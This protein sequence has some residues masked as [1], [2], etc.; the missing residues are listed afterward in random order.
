M[1]KSTNYP[2]HHFERSAD[3]SEWAHKSISDLII[4]ASEEF[5]EVINNL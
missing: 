4:D 2:L 5:I 1:I 3:R